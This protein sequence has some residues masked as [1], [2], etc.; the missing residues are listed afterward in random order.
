MKDC[1]F[2]DEPICPHCE[3]KHEDWFEWGDDGI[4]E[5]D[6]CGMR[7]IFAATSTISFET[8]CLEHDFPPF[9]DKATYRAC[10]RCGTFDWR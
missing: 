1:E 9:H 7:F 10:N 2:S 3:H 5:C 6:S 8:K 4:R